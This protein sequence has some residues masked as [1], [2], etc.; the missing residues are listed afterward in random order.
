MRERLRRGLR[1]AAPQKRK[2]KGSVGQY[3]NQEEKNSV[4]KQG[5]L[6]DQVKR[7][8]SKHV[9]VWADTIHALRNIT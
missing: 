3:T 2:M 6:C 7:A 9:C 4:D 1:H 8:I 5:N